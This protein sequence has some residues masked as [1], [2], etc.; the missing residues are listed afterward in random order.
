MLPLRALEQ[1]YQIPSFTPGCRFGTIRI[2]VSRGHE[3]RQVSITSEYSRGSRAIHS[4]RSSTSGSVASAIGFLPK[5][6]KIATARL[7][8]ASAADLKFLHYLLRTH[9]GTSN[10]KAALERYQS[11]A[12]LYFRSSYQR[13][14]QWITNFGNGALPVLIAAK[15]TEV[16]S[17]EP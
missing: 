5:F 9:P 13:L 2:V 8:R 3:V 16:Q 11:V 14:P 15:G 4:T 17:A 10:R 6:Q 1:F 7:L 12:P